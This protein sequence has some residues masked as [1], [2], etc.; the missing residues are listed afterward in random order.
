MSF[1]LCWRK[2]QI[3]H[4]RRTHEQHHSNQL[5]ESVMQTGNEMTGREGN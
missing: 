4:I 1:G 3:D 2:Y 5:I